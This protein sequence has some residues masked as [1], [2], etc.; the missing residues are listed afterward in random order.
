[1]PSGVQSETQLEEALTKKGCV[2]AQLAHSPALGPVQVAQLAEHRTQTS[3]AL[4]EPPAHVKPLRH[5]VQFGLGVTVWL[6]S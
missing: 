6:G 1:M 4:A 3:D 5:V 2:E